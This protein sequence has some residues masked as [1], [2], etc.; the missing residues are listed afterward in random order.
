M[1]K[2]LSFAL[3]TMLIG[4]SLPAYAQQQEKLYRIGFLSG[5]FSGPRLM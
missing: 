5:G 1:K 4:V 2:I 3:S